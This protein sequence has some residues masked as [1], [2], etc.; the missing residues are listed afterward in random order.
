MS[1][2]RIYLLAAGGHAR[3]LLDALFTLNITVDG[4]IDAKS[5]QSVLNVSVLGNDEWLMQQKMESISLVNG[6]GVAGN[7]LKKRHDLF[8]ALTAKGFN[9]LSV[10][11]TAHIS[12]LYLCTPG[13]N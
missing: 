10:H 3:F 5:N 12:P 4:I 1:E 6:L 11:P 7:T 9:F 13:F 2:H 8:S